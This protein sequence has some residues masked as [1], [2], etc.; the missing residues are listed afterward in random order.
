M[1]TKTAQANIGKTNLAEIVSPEMDESKTEPV[2]VA[3]TMPQASDVKSAMPEDDVP[4]VDKNAPLRIEQIEEGIEN[5]PQDKLNGRLYFFGG[6]I[7]VLIILG[8]GG[9][10]FFFINNQPDRQNVIVPVT[11]ESVQASPSAV[12]VRSKWSLE[13]LDGSG[14]PGVFK[15]VTDE[16]TALGYKVFQIGNV[17]R[18]IYKGNTLFVSQ[19]MEDK[20]NL[21]ITD[22]T[23]TIEIS[24]VAG[25]LSDSTA[26]ARII[27][28]K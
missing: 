20:V 2:V 25:I 10:I 3:P 16:L 5:E 22:L 11:H 1:P 19:E 17:G 26:S 14:V 21:L 6:L 18:K 7:L 8:V 4:T 23:G 24:T 9:F 12:F 13:V 27:V 28:G 15:K